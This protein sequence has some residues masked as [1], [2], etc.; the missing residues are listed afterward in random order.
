MVG[1][2]SK[3]LALPTPLLSPVTLADAFSQSR[4]YP[5]LQPAA[6]GCFE[7][8]YPDVRPWLAPETRLEIF[9]ALDPVASGADG[10]AKPGAPLR[11]MGGGMP[12]TF[13]APL[14]P[15]W[16]NAL[17][18]L[19]GGA[20]CILGEHIAASAYA[21]AMGVSSAPPAR[22]MHVQLL[23][24]LVC[25]GRAAVFEAATSPPRGGEPASTLATLRHAKDAGRAVECMTWWASDAASGS[26]HASV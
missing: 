14:S 2:H 16:C 7:T 8:L 5:L 12:S 19:H 17:G 26:A 10:A 20:A 18:N 9:P 15:V 22:T 3:M 21:Q 24:G 23:S 25:D 4:V 13:S 1:R 6:L 11:M